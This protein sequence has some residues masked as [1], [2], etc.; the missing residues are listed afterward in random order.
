MAKIKLIFSTIGEVLW[1]SFGLYLKFLKFGVVFGGVGSAIAGDI[2]IL[3]IG[4][5]AAF[6]P[7]LIE[8]VAELG[9]EITRTGKSTKPGINHAFNKAADALDKQEKKAEE[10]SAK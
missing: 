9:E 7:S 3:F 6:V 10:K 5:L 4:L 1:R 8:A 2:K